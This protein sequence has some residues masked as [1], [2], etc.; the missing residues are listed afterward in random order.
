MNE[1]PNE[2]VGSE[3]VLEAFGY[4]TRLFERDGD[5]HKVLMSRFVGL[6][7]KLGPV[8]SIPAFFASMSLPEQVAVAGAYA[9]F[10]RIVSECALY[11]I[12]ASKGTT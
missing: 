4:A 12:R 10:G 6:V 7:K 9:A 3:H 5:V 11:T 1:T 8:D 2:A